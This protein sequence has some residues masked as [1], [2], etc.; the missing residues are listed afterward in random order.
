MKK[1]LTAVVLT[2]LLLSLTAGALA[3]TGLGSVITVT[4]TAATAEKAGSVSGY[5]YMCAVTLDDEGKVAGV[6][7][8][9]AQP[10][11]SFDTTG[12]IVGETS[13]VVQSKN[14][15]KEGYGM[16]GVSP[17]GKEWYEQ[18]EVLS[19]W[20]VGKTPAEIL[21]TPLDEGG[22]P[23]DADLVSGCTVHIND[24]LVAF[25]KAVAAAK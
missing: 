4:N 22:H 11:G 24:Q 5:V 3:A 10:A 13:I 6:V 12:A 25:E 2:A 15:I 1:I 17:I 23:T 9:A 20:C 14:E 21:A 8:D 7:F 16:K 18:M 19:A